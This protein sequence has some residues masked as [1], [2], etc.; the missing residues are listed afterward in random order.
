MGSSMMGV[1]GRRGKEE[2]ERGV[3]RRVLLNKK[4]YGSGE[5]DRKR[6]VTKKRCVSKGVL[7]GGGG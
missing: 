6:C 5:Y 7:M 3:K 2:G 4:V 1:N